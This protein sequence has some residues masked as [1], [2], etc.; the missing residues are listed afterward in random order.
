MPLKGLSIDTFLNSVVEV[1]GKILNIAAGI[2]KY[3][4]GGTPALAAA[5]GLD[6]SL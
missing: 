5:L 4:I 6:L 3:W 2:F 1:F